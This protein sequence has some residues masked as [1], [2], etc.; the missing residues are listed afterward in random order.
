MVVATRALEVT[1]GGLLGRLFGAREVAWQSLTLGGASLNADEFEALL[2]SPWLS[3]LRALQL[4][5]IRWTRQR[6]ERFARCPLIQGLSW[7][8]AGGDARVHAIL[9]KSPYLARCYVFEPVPPA[10]W[11]GW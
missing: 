3:Q 2:V 10:P 9:S 7:L 1:A 5:C 11:T 4:S 8:D 6:A